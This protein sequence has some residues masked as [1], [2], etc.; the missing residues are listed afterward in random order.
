VSATEIALVVV[1]SVCLAIAAAAVARLR[2]R[3]SK[4]RAAALSFG[5][6]GVLAAL[7]AA[8]MAAQGPPL[9]ILPTATIAALCFA[10]AALFVPTAK[11]RFAAFERDVWAHVQRQS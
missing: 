8:W 1:C 7:S 3:M 6:P 11:T 2:P 9:A 5:A 10:A 4:H